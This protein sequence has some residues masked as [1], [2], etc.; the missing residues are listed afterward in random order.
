MA[1]WTPEGFIGQLF[2]TL[3]KH[4]PP[5]AGVKSPALWGTRE[6]LTE[7]FGD[8]ASS[9]EARS[10]DFVF[11]YRSPEH[12]LEVF[13]TYYGPLLKAFATL[14]APAQA[15][16]TADVMDLVRRFNR[17]G[18]DSMVV[19]SEYLEIVITRR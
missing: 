19:P 17:S 18:D 4:V 14:D 5:P 1:N 7:L 6:R 2:K 15:K 12:W 10:R 9:I 13:K 3:G 11:R 16:L 8:S